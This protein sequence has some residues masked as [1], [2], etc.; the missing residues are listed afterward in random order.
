MDNLSQ[1]LRLMNENQQL[2]KYIIENQL[3]VTPDINLESHPD[4]IKMTS[5]EQ[6]KTEEVSTMSS[7]YIVLR[8]S[9]SPT[10]SQQL[11]QSFRPS[12]I[13]S[14]VLYIKS[15]QQRPLI[16]YQEYH[17]EELQD[18]TTDEENPKPEGN[19]LE[20]PRPHCTKVYKSHAGLKYHLEHGQCE[21][22]NINDKSKVYYCKVN[23][24]RKRY[25]SITGLVR[26][27]C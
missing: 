8:H 20:C 14:D 25:K 7:E 6:Q 18:T 23:A 27:H 3:S 1:L 19:T 21:G 10:P 26:Y 12:L 15:N 5:L 17:Q 11:F 16:E 22:D 2:S 13:K 9:H 4:I 24:C